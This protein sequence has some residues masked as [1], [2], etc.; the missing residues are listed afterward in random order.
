MCKKHS[1]PPYFPETSVTNETW[2]IFQRLQGKL[3]VTFTLKLHL[4]NIDK[5]LNL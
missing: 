4:R 1:Y 3:S 2:S 5:S